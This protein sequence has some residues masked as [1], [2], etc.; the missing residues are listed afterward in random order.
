MSRKIPIA[1]QLTRI[2]RTK[3]GISRVTS[4]RLVMK[5][6]R[7]NEL[8]PLHKRIE[9]FRESAG[10][11][12]VRANIV[13]L[14]IKSK[15]IMLNMSKFIFHPRLGFTPFQNGSLFVDG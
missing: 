2:E 5:T 3:L 11:R 4:V 12:Q 7:F 14:V 6:D 1:G 13:R 9:L 10:K 8:K 15:P